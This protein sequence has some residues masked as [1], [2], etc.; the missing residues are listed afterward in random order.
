MKQ[1]Y[2]IIHSL[3]TAILAWLSARLGILL[4]VMCLLLVMYGEEKLQYI[5]GWYG[6]WNWSRRT[7][8]IPPANGG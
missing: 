6:K 8:R 3:L 2:L 4:P 5:G 7:R 1:L